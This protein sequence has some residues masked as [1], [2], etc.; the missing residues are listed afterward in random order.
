M[1]IL[2]F[3]KKNNPKPLSQTQEKKIGYKN[4]I[5][6]NGKTIQE[7][8]EID[9]N[10]AR[11]IYPDGTPDYLGM[12]IVSSTVP[13]KNNY[14][15][16]N[17]N[18]KLFFQA[19]YTQL[20]ENNLLPLKI[21]LTRMAT[22]GF[23]VD[24]VGLCYIGKINLCQKPVS[25]AIMKENNKRATKIFDN[26][27]DAEKFILDKSNYKIEVRQHENSNSMQ[28]L[29]GLSIVKNLSDLSVE[30]CIENIPYWIKY[31]KYCKRA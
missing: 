27:S 6:P 26:K 18:E 29:Q 19:F 20:C 24:Y 17:E 3:F 22:G 30:Q 10:I 31:I 21:K 13:P 25:Y 23:N 8:Q 12:K 9:L 11:G 7:Q 28:Y 5:L 14:D 1:R 4:I 16:L 2:N 15:I